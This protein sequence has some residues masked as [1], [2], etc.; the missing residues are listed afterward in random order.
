MARGKVSF[1]SWNSVE[2]I[3]YWKSGCSKC[4]L[5]G[6]WQVGFGA[7]FTWFCASWA[8]CLI[9]NVRNDQQGF[10]A[11]AYCQSANY[12]VFGYKL[13]WFERLSWSMCV[14]VCCGCRQQ[15]FS[16]SCCSWIPPVGFNGK[17]IT[18]VINIGIGGSDLVR[19]CL[20][21]SV[22]TMHVL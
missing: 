14:C 8:L 18:D 4:P 15:C 22:G 21:V 2:L 16:S 13:I 3:I 6:Y 20:D 17:A 10:M 1:P 9:T 7:L 11:K 5:V 19:V 12:C